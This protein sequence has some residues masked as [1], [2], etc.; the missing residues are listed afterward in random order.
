MQYI[1]D[2]HNLIPKVRGIE[3]AHLDD[4]EALIEKLISFMRAKRSRAVV[5]FDQAAE[6]RAG[7]QNRGLVRAVFVPRRQI[8]D[9]AIAAYI[10]KLGGNARNCT[11]VSSDRMVQAAGRAHHVSILSSADFARQMDMLPAPLQIPGREKALSPEE[12]AEWEELFN[13]YGSNPPDGLIP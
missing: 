13:Q 4:E 8:A 9:D 12:V 2:G 7:E 3:L 11:L 10:K 1:I 5:F 6:G